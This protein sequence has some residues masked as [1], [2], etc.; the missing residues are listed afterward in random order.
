MQKIVRAG[1]LKKWIAYSIFLCRTALVLAV[2]IFNGM[3][4]LTYDELHILLFV[5]S[6][7]TILYFVFIGKFIS[8]HK[9]YFKPG[10]IIGKGELFLSFFPFILLHISEFILIY[11]KDVIYSDNFESLLLWI[12]IIESVL[13][14]YTGFHLSDV[15][16]SD[17]DDKAQSD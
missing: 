1:A 13:S 17:K 15:F 5:I 14:A 11:F 2:N 16:S 10:G 8:V 7:L 9:R 6:P 12:V 4:R 3:G